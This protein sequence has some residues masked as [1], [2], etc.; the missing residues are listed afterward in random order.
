M[1]NSSRSTRLRPNWPPNVTAT[2]L[3]TGMK[4]VDAGIFSSARSRFATLSLLGFLAVDLLHLAGCRGL[5]LLA[6]ALRR[7]NS[8]LDRLA[9]RVIGVGDHLPRLLRRI[10]R[11]LHGLAA[12]QLDRL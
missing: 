8:V 2:R 1:A 7:R 10:L 11:P 5:Q 12:R 3:A 6:L 9:H 4:A